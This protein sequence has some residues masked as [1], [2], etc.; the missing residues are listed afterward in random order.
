MANKLALF[1]MILVW[2]FSAYAQLA[3]LPNIEKIKERLNKSNS[4]EI[5]SW[6]IIDNRLEAKTAGYRYVIDNQSVAGVL[7]FN[8]GDS[9][10]KMK[11]ITDRCLQLTESVTGPLTEQDKSKVDEVIDDSLDIMGKQVSDHIGDYRFYNSVVKHG[12]TNTFNCGVTI[13]SN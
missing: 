8:A 9:R 4:V 7:P 2:N 10:A 13:A 6:Q 3:S 1:T 5:S 11:D 12:D